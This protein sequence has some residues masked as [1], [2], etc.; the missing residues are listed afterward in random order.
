MGR[1]AAFH[2]LPNMAA[3]GKAYTSRFSYGKLSP[4]TTQARGSGIGDTNRGI[5][6]LNPVANRSI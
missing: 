1:P 6:L 2:H 4:S 3:G 5:F